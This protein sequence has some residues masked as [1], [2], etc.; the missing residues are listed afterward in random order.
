MTATIKTKTPA[1][2]PTYNRVLSSVV[3][4]V[5][6]GYTTTVL[7]PYFELMYDVPRLSAILKSLSNAE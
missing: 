5:G 3:L 1:P 4:I 2:T 7:P 6:V